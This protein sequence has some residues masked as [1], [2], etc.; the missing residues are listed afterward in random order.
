MNR[1]FLPFLAGLTLVSGS[2]G[3]QEPLRGPDGGTSTYVSGVQL[4]SIPGK[5]FSAKTSTEWAQ[6]VA[7]GSTIA[8]HLEAKLARD[9]HGRIYR[10]NHTFVPANSNLKS[11]LYQVHIYDPVTRTQTLCSVRMRVCVL[12]DYYPMTFFETAAT[13]LNPTG[14]RSL[15]REN[16]GSDVIEGMYVTGTRETT[17]INPG[18][19][20]NQQPLVSIRDFWYSSE[21]QTNLAVTRNDPVEGMQVI[22][23]SEISQTEPD[24]HLFDIPIGYTVRDD[25]ISARHGR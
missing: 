15:S 13:G 10:E 16:L 14:T 8:K 1:L 21:L 12:T 4:L 17:T 23:L 6:P 11:P 5:P 2:L 25:R 24:P 19:V 9:S 7:D 3:A 20:G 22:R 18:A